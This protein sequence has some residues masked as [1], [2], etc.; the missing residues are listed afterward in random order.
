MSEIFVEGLG[1]IQIQGSTPNEEE[2]K[3]ILDQLKSK[4]NQSLQ[5]M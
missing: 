4:Q 1:N 5:H 2:K 3:S